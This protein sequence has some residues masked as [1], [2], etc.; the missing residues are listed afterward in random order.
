VT[1]LADTLTA[2]ALTAGALLLLAAL[3]GAITDPA[4]CWGSCS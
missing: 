1:R 4:T 2:A 3:A